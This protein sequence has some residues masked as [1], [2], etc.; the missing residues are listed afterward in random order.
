MNWSLEKPA[1]RHAAAPARSVVGKSTTAMRNRA[2]A[3]A[4]LRLEVSAQ[5]LLRLLAGGQLCAADF[6]C[7]DC[8]SKQCVWR[9]LLMSCEKTLHAAAGCNGS[10]NQC[11]GSS[12]GA[13]RRPGAVAL[14]GKQSVP[15]VLEP[16][17]ETTYLEGL[18]EEVEG[19]KE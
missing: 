5:T 4:H 13:R 18:I 12:S 15:A 11:G 2:A 3:N 16:E 19:E 17:P 8:E 6:R 9:I 7:L 10:C 14:P 1:G